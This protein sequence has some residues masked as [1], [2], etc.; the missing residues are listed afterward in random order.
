MRVSLRTALAAAMALGIAALALWWL[1]RDPVAARTAEAATPAGLDAESAS[2]GS[3]P[4]INAPGRAG[5]PG[6]PLPP[7]D[8]PLGQLWA[9][10]QAP[11][12]AGDSGA[13]CRL[14]LETVR[15]V[16]AVRI[17]E[18]MAP[19]QADEPSE[20][21]TLRDFEAAPGSFGRPAE[22]QDP[23]TRAA[24]D[25]TARRASAAARRCEGLTQDRAE[26]ALALLRAAAWAGQPDAQAVYAAGEGWFLSLPGAMGRPEFEQWRREAP[27]VV[28]RMLDEGHPEAPGLLAGAYS[29]QTWLGGLYD[30]DLERAAAYLFLNTRLM[31]KPEMAERLLDHVPAGVKA[32]ARQQANALYERHYQGRSVP[33]AGFYLGAGVRILNS[34]LFEGET[35]PLPCA[36]QA[37]PPPAVDDGVRRR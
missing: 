30:A 3:G 9:E 29:S 20:L 19:V 25:D 13:A 33:R 1:Q 2:A 23:Q 6:V 14:A 16:S 28:A 4:G 8:T 21:Q 7:R 31:G 5:A 18:M 24:L 36:P 10:L 35:K 26:T 15:C 37:A 32:R 12:Q 34:G 27:L 22:A 11:A 17:A